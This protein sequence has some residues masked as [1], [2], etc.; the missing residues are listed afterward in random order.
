[1]IW[2]WLLYAK[3]E[4]IPISTKLAVWLLSI[5]FRNHKSHNMYHIKCSLLQYH[6]TPPQSLQ[7]VRC[8]SCSQIH[9]PPH[10]L[11]WDFWRPCIQMDVPPHSLH[12]DFW[13]PCWHIFVVFF[14][15]VFNFFSLS[16]G[17]IIASVTLATSLLLLLG[18]AVLLGF[19]S[20]DISLK[21][22]SYPRAN[23]LCTKLPGNNKPSFFFSPSQ[24]FFF[25]P[26]N[27][28]RAFSWTKKF[29][30]N[31]PHDLPDEKNIQLMSIVVAK[32]VSEIF[33]VS[34]TR[35]KKNHKISPLW[36]EI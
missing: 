35:G 10:S 33:T 28:P 34:K 15:F 5:V 19:A 27:S 22:Y 12:C 6:I 1:M 20:S 8:L 3:I 36:F 32:N 17:W 26:P 4:G 24:F 16:V 23:I 11:Q 30:G 9:F 31:I 21:N 13:R 7:C 29:C 2:K 25:F 14:E 18:L